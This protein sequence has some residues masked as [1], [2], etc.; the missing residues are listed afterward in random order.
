MSQRRLVA[1]ADHLSEAS[2][3]KAV[4]DPLAEVITLQATDAATVVQ[5]AP[6]V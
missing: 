6:E 5:A 4:L 3:E 1:I 2:V